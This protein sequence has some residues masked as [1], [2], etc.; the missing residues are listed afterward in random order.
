MLIVNQL[1]HFYQAQKLSF[2]FS[3]TPGSTTAILGPS[4]AGKST[5]L[6][7]LCGLLPPSSGLVTFENSDVPKEDFTHKP[8]HERP[9]SILFQEHNLFSHFSIF[10]NIAI[11]IS[12]SLRLSE[13]EKE[14]VMQ[15]AKKVGL[16]NYLNRQPSELSGGQ[17]QRVALARSLVRDKPL[18]LLDEPFSALDPALRSDM[19]QEVKELAHTFGT[20]IL[21]VTHHPHDAKVIA[22]GVIFID[23]GRV[24]H[25]AQINELNNPSELIRPY[26]NA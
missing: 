21:M 15:A 23:N 1:S 14:A 26:L 17:K 12:P 7:L 25:H 22:D 5:L 16:E 6:S 4:G 8:A 24:F 19:L 18:L 9:L 20:T 13:N 11:G 3:L 2:S 10:D